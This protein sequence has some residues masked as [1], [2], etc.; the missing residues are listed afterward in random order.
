MALPLDEEI[1]LWICHPRNLIR[2]RHENRTR[3]GLRPRFRARNSGNLWSPRENVGSGVVV[4]SWSGREPAGIG[5]C[6]INDLG[7]LRFPGRS[8][9][10]L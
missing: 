3:H 5:D 1:V 6:Q 9:V 7:G 10:G 8:P 2:H 4:G